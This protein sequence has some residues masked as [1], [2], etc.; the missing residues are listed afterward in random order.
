MLDIRLAKSDE[1]DKIIEF[2]YNLI[3][4][5][6]NT[7]Y[8]PKWKKGIY[9]TDQ[10]IQESINDNNLFIGIIN[11][12]IVSAMVMNHDCNDGYESVKWQI[13]AK[14]NEIIIIH[15]LG[16]STAYQGQGIAKQMV[17][18]AIED[19]RKM[20]MKTIRLDVLSSNY[21]AQRL[22][23]VMGFH[24]IDTMKLFYEDTGLVD[25]LLYEYVL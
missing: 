1:Y 24:Y 21:P 12:N 7:E 14:Q 10:F 17:S 16:I 25:F 6:Q 20:N 8:K 5:M 2:Y 15:T 3:D 11:N 9:P 23:Q 18:Y 22:Y 13:T 4:S 19:C